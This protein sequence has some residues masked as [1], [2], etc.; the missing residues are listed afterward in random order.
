MLILT[1][2]IAL[3]G[4][5]NAGC[6][7]P[8]ANYRAIVTRH[9]NGVLKDPDSAHIKIGQIAHWDE[10]SIPDTRHYDAMEAMRH[11]IVPCWYVTAAVNGK[12]S[13]GGY[14]GWRGYILWVANGEVVNMIERP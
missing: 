7:K 2:T 1:T 13:F 10:G 5:A 8:P 9:L 6:D 4:V 3:I 14:S 12:N 11:P